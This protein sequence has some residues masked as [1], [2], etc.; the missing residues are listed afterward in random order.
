MGTLKIAK[1]GCDIDGVRKE[2]VAEVKE[3]PRYKYLPFILL[4]LNGAKKQLERYIETSQHNENSGMFLE[5]LHETSTLFEDLN[6]LGKYIDK[7]IDSQ[8]LQ[9]MKE[10]HYLWLNIRNHIRHDIR[11]GFDREMDAR[12]NTRAKELG[13][14]PQL[15]MDI[16]LRVDFIQIGTTIVTIKEIS[17]YL[18]WATDFNKTLLPECAELIEKLG[19][20]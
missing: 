18:D 2:V 10:K 1:Q 16:K 15:Q 4:F 8:D 6:T 17:D 14:D 9:E 5:C 19:R 7:C 12:K 11:E 20:E 13:L 3:T